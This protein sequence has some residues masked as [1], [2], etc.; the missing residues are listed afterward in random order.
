MHVG[1]TFT[2]HS[3]AVGGG[4]TFIQSVLR[5]LA[6]ASVDHRWTLVGNHRQRP[7]DLQ[8]P[9]IGYLSLHRSAVDVRFDAFRDA[10]DRARHQI[11]HVRALRQIPRQRGYVD[12]LVRGH[13]IEMLWSLTP[14]PLSTE[15]PFFTTVWDLQHRLQPWFPEVSAGHTWLDRERLFSTVLPRAAGIVVGTERGRDEVHEFYRVPRKRI[16]V[17]PF[18]V[19]TLPVAAGASD[20]GI[21]SQYGLQA[22]YAFYPAQFWPHKNHVNLLQAIRLLSERGRVLRLVCTG[23]DGGN[24][25]HV[26]GVIRELGLADQ[27]ALLGFVPADHLP[28]LYRGAAC[29]CFPSFFG[30]DNL[31]PLEAMAYGCPVVAARVPGAEEQ[32]ADAVTLFD[33]ASPPSIAEALQMVIEDPAERRRLTDRGMAQALELTPASYVDRVST[34][35]TQFEPHRRCWPV[36]F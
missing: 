3:P 23:S 24:L 14:E 21:L 27:V 28:A 25:E 15:L 12:E 32:L 36:S 13:G 8:S 20:P 34:L 29:L 35:I 5:G 33:P 1:I 2:G 17:V 6:T 9:N 18:P 11:R 7:E 16:H 4:F 19:P 31:P 26:K 10:L 22:G 30:P